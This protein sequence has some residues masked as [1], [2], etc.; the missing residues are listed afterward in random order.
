L[1]SWRLAFNGAEPVRSETLEEFVKTFGECGFSPTALYPCYGMAETTLFTTGDWRQTS[2]LTRLIDS[3]A[4]AKNQIVVTNQPIKDQLLTS[5]VSC[6]RTWL[7][8]EI[9]IVDPELLTRCDPDR[10]GEIWVASQSV[11]QGYWNNP[12]AT[13]QI[14]QARIKNDQNNRQFLRTGDLGFIHDNQ[15]FVTG[16]L[17]DI[18]IIRGRNHYP[19]D[20]EL[21][22]ANSHPALTPNSGAAFMVEIGGEEKLVIAQE[23]ERSQR[24]QLDQEAV[25]FAVYTAVSEFHELQIHALLLLKPGTIPKTSSGKIQRRACHQAFL[26]ETFELLVEP[27]VPESNLSKDRPDHT[28]LQI[29]NQ[30]QHESFKVTDPALVSLVTNAVRQQIAFTLEQPIDRILADRSFHSFGTDS[31]KAV[32]IIENISGQLDLNLL[33]TLLFEYST[34]TDLATYLVQNHQDHLSTKLLNSSINDAKISLLSV[35]QEQKRPSTTNASGDIAVIGMS[36]RFP[37]APNLES[38][39]ELLTNGKTA[40]TEVPT[41]RWDRHWYDINPEAVNKT[42]SRWG[43]FIDGIDLFD[44]FFFQISP[45]E[46][47]LMDPQQ[48]IFLEVAW[49]ALEDAGY[50]PE[51]LDTKSAGVFVGCSKN[52]Y[53]RHIEGQL[54]PGDYSAGIGNQ[55]P[56]IANRVS[57]FLNLHGPSVLVDTLCSS[58]LVSIHMA[59]QSI[60]Q[61]E[62][63]TAIAGG[64]NLQLS[65]EYYVGMS[66]MKVHSPTGQCYAFDDR[67][68]GIVLGEGVG[69]VLLKPLDQAIADGDSIY[70]IIKGS[71]VNN[72][73]RTNGLTAPNPASQADVISLALDNAGVAADTI[74][75]VEAHGTGTSLGDPIEI[76]GLTKAFRVDTDQNHFCAI[77]SVKTNLGHLE[78]AAGIAQFIKVMLSLRHEQLPPSL[79]FERPNPYIPFDTSPFV[80]NQHLQ[81]WKSSTPRRAGISSFGMGGTNAHVVVEEAPTASVNLKMVDRSHHLLLLSAKSEKALDDLVDRYQQLLATYPD[82]SLANLCFTAN[83][84]RVQFNE[85]LGVVASSIG[86]LAVQLTTYRQQQ[87]S[88]NI[89]R[90]SGAK[91]NKAKIACLF[92]G[93][94]SQYLQMG[95]QLYETQP[96]FRQ[97]MIECATL[98]GPYLNQS[99]IGLLYPV[100]GESELIHQ[101]IYAQPALFALEY[102]LFKLWQSWGI[103]PDALLG[104]SLGEYVAAV[105]AGMMSLADGIKLVTI[106]AKLMQD[107]PAE[108]SMLA[109]FA[110][111]VEIQQ[112]LLINGQQLSFAVYNSP[113]NTV[114]AGDQ[115]A[116]SHACEVLTKAGMK[117]KKLNTSNAFHSSLMEPMITEFR[118]AAT[119]VTYHSPKITLIS[120]LTGAPIDKIDGEYWCQH[121]RQSVKFADGLQSLADLNINVFLEIGPKPTLIGIGQQ[122]LATGDRLWLSSLR[123]GTADG[124]QILQCVAQMAISGVEIDWVA[125]DYEFDRHRI[126]LPTYPF[127]RKSYW[128]SEIKD[129]KTST[130]N[131]QVSFSSTTSPSPIID[132]SNQ[133]QQ[134][135]LAQLHKNTASLLK[136]DPADIDVNVPFLEMG[137]DSLVLIE[138]VNHIERTF[139]LKISIRQIFEELTTI[140]L[141]ANYIHEQRPLEET[142]PEPVLAAVGNTVK[143]LTVSNYFPSTNSTNGNGSSNGQG[144]NS[145]PIIPIQPNGNTLSIDAPIGTAPAMLERVI[146]Q[147]MQIQLQLMSKQL[148]TVQGSNS[149]GDQSSPVENSSLQPAQLTHLAPQNQI[150]TVAPSSKSISQS[151]S[152]SFWRFDPSSGKKQLSTQQQ[153]HLDALIA[154]Y[155]QRTQKSKQRARSC[156]SFLADKRAAIGFRFETKEMIYPITGSHSLGSKVWD[157][158]DNEYIDISMGFGVHLFGHSESFIMSALENQLRQGIHIGPLSQLSDKVALLISELT[159]MERVCFSNSGTEAVMTAVRLA[160]STT[161]RNKIVI[162]KDSYHGHSDGTLAVA[163]NEGSV[164]MAPGVTQN[165]VDDVLVL[166]Y[167]DPQSLDIIKAHAHELAAVLVEPVPSRRPDVQPQEFLQQLRQLTTE[168]NIALIFD[169]VITGFRIHPGGAQAWFGIEADIAT[170]G[171]I[172]GGGMPIGVI[173]GKALYLD[174]IDGGD[175]QYED[176]SYP[177]AETTFFAGTFSRNPLAM[178]AAYAVLSQIKLQGLPLYQQLNQRTARLAQTINDFFVREQVPV[179]I[180]NFGSLFRFALAGNASYLY[181]PLEMDLFYYHLIEK[182]VYV[183]EGRTCFLSTSHTDADINY[184]IQAVQDSVRLMKEGGFWSQPSSPKSVDNPTQRQ[185]VTAS[186]TTT[187]QTE[188]QD[189]V[190]LDRVWNQRRSPAIVPDQK[191]VVSISPIHL[192]PANTNKTLDFSLYYFGEYAAEFSQGK[193]DLLF[194]GAKFADQNGFTA[195]WI[196]ERHF[197][198]FGGF[199][200]N[201]SVIGAG[202][203]RETKKIQIRAGSVVLPLHH[204]IRV[205]EEWSVVDNLSQGRVGIA[206]A[207]GWHPNDFALAP[208]SYGNHRELMFQGIET[209][210]KLWR[211]ESIPVRGGAGNE[212]EVQTFPMPMQPQL[213]IWITVVN[214]PETYIR[215]GEIGAGILTNLMNQ[216]VEDLATNIAL[217]REALARNGHD[218][219]SATV[220]VLLH[221]LIGKDLATIRDQ[222]RQPFCNYLRSSLG[223]FQ[224][225]VKSQG[226]QVDLDSLSEDDKNY[227]LSAAYERYVQTSALI[228]TPDSCAPIIDNLRSIGVDEIACFIDFGVDMNGVLESLPYVNELKDRFQ[229]KEQST[230]EKFIAVD[231]A[232]S[233]P[234]TEAQ[235]Q[236][237]FLAQLGDESSIAY[238]ESITLEMQGNLNLGAMVATIQKVVDRH[239]A[240]RTIISEQ[241]DY[242]E[243]LPVLKIDVPIINLSNVDDQAAEFQVTKWLKEKSQ[244]PFDLARGPLFRADILQ[245]AEKKHLLLV[246]AHHIIVDGWSMGLIV[247]EIG[248]IYSA[249]CQGKTVQLAAPLQFREY[250]NWQEQQAT[251]TEI[252]AHES[253]WLSRF[254]GSIPVL[255]LPTDRPRPAVKTFRADQQTVQVSADLSNNLRRIS[256]ENGCTLFM[257]LFSAYSILLKRLTG[258]DD[259]LVGIPTA[260]RSLK[261][262]EGLVG[263][264]THFLPIYCQLEDDLTIVASFK[265]IRSILLDAYDHQD[266]PFAWLINNLAARKNVD[267]PSLITTTFNIDPSMTAPEIVGLQTNL[268]PGQISFADYEIGLNVI[269]SEQGLILNCFYNADLFDGFKITGMLENFQVL[270]TEIVTDIAQQISTLS[271]IAAAEQQKLLV[272]WNH[273]QADYPHEHCIHQLFEAQVNKIPEAIAIVCGDEQLTYQELN[274]RANQLAHHLQTLEIK[275]EVP[276]GVCISRSIEMMVGILGILKAGGAYV[277]LDPTYPAERLAYMLDDA[278]VPV[279]LTESGLRANLPNHKAQVVCLDTDWPTIAQHSSNNCVSAVSPTNLVY[280]IYTSG[281]T[282][283]PKGTMIQHQSLVSYTTTTIR[284]Y[285]MQPTD[286]VLQFCSISFDVAAE[287]IYPCLSSGGALVMRNDEMVGSI[288]NFLATCGAWGITMLSLPT[289][290]WHE[291]V[292]ALGTQDVTMPEAMRLVIIAGE[293]ARP[294]Q[295]AKWQKYCIGRPRLIN[296]YGVTEST[297]IS[298]IGELTH[299]RPTTELS[300][301]KVIDNTQIYLLDK[302]LQ[303]VPIGIPGEMYLGGLLLA[304]GYFNRPDLT[305]E[306]F[307]PHPFSTEPGARIYKTGDLA[308]YRADSSIEC[309]GRIDQQVKIRGFR[310]ELGEVEGAISKHPQVSQVTVIDREDISGNKQLVA[311]IVPQPGQEISSTELRTFLKE[312]LPNHMLPAAFVSLHEFPFTPN[313]KIDRQALP[314]PDFTQLQSEEYVAP[315]NKVEEQLS[316]IW[317]EV[318]GV[319]RVGVHD[320]FFELGGHSLLAT[321]LISRIR[322]VFEVEVPLRKLFEFNTIDTLAAQ[323]QSYQADDSRLGV[324]PLRPVSRTENLPLSFAQQRLWFLDQLEP[325]SSAY[326]MPGAVKLQGQLDLA[327]LERSL[328]EVVRRH[329]SLRTNFI[330]SQDGQPRQV[331][332]KSGDWQMKVIDLQQMLHCEREAQIQQ[333]ATAEATK[334]FALDTDSLLRVTVLLVSETE[335]ILLLT[336]HHIVSDGWSI[337]VL[338]EEIAT[339]YSAFIQGNT[340]PLLELEIQYVDFAVWQRE[341]LQGDTLQQQINYWQQQLAGAPALLELSTDRPRPPVQTFNGANYESTISV[342]ILESLDKLTQQEGA[343]LFMTLLAAFD[344]LLYRYTGQA[345]IVVGSPIANRNHAEIENL[346]GFFA[347]TLILRNDLSD[348]PTFRELLQRVREVALGAYAHQD[349]PFE[350]LVETLQPERNLSYSPLFQVM[351]ILQNTP[352]SDLQMPGVTLSPMAAAGSI[353]TFDITLS[354][355]NT[356]E[357]LTAEWEYNTDLFNASTIKHM[358]QHLE[359]LL[360]GIAENPDSSIAMLP[361]LTTAEQQQLLVDWNDTQADYPHEQCIHQLF[362]AQVDKTPEVIAI[363]CGDEQLTYRELNTR[364]NQLAHHLQI[365]GIKQDEFVGL[366]VERSLEMIVGMLAILKAGGAYVPLDSEYPAERLAYMV[367]DAQISLLLTQERLLSNLPAHNAQVICLDRDW[368]IIEQANSNN[369]LVSTNS[370]DSLAYVIYTSGSTGQPKGVM[371]TQQNLTNFCHAA[372]NAYDITSADRILQFASVSFDVAAEE[373]YPGLIQGA[374]IYLRTPKML[375]SLPAFWQ[376]C[377]AWRLTLLD[378][379]TAYWQQ[380]TTDLASIPASVRLVIIGGERANPAQVRLWQ[381]QV[382][383]YPQL[384]NAYGPT[385]TTVEATC[386]NLSQVQLPPGQEVP[387]GK[388]LANMQV[389][390]LDSQLQLV[391]VGTPGELHIG[392]HGVAKGYL[393]RPDLTAEKF[394]V[395]PFSDEPQARLYKTGDLVRYL[396]DGN[397]E[398]LGRIDQQVKIRGF[399]IELG[400]VEAAISKHSQIAQVTVIDSYACAKGDREDKPGNKVL[401]AYLVTQPG[402]EISST[403]LRTF[404][405]GQLPDYMLPTIAICLEELPVTPNGKID[406]KALPVPDFTQLQAAE[407]VAPRN[408][409]EEQ[410]SSIWQDVLG[411]DQVGVHDNFFELGGHSLLATQL[412]SRIRQTFEIEVPLRKLFEFNTIDALAAQIQSYQADD[413]RLGVIP[414]RPVSRTENLPLSF[415]QQR[416]WFLDQLEPNSSAYNMPGAVK[417]QG[418]LDLAILERTLGEVVRRHE[419]LRTNFIVSQDGQPR[420]V[421]NESGDWQMKVIDLQQMPHREREAQIQQLASAEA[422]KPF[423]LG[424]DSLLRVTVLLVSATEQILLLTMHH[425]VSDGWSIGVLIE[426]IATLY[427]AFIQGNTSPLLELEIQ[428]V[429][430][431][432]WQREWLQGDTLQ[433]QINYWQQQL[434]GAP[435][436][437]ELPTD[438]PRPPVQTFNGADYESTISAHVAESLD[439]LTQQEGVTLFMTLLAAFD[440]LLYRYTGQ[441]DIVVGSPI[442]NRNHAEIENLIGFFANTLILRNDLSDNPTFRELLQ[443][444]R[445]VA[446]GAY[447]H[448]DLPFEMLVETLQPERNLSYSPLFQVMFILQNTPGSDLQMPGVTLSPI[449]AAGSIST[450]DITLSLTNTPEGLIAEWEYNTDLFNA[451]TIERMAQHLEILLTAIAENPDLS[452]STLPMLTT[453][454]QQQ[455]LVDWNDTQADYPQEQCVHQ[456]FEAQVNKTP[457]AI[458]IVCGDEQLT[459]QELNTRANQLAHHLQTLGIKPEVPVGVCI[460]RSIEMMVGIIGVLKAG[461]AYVP[462]DPTYPAERLAYML[463]DAQVPVLLTESGLKANLPNHMAQVVCLDTDWQTIAQQSGN[464]CVSAVSPTN[465][466]YIIYTSGST[467]KPKGTMIQHQSL[468]SYTTTTIREYDMRPTDKVLQFCSISFDVAAEEIYPCLSSGGALV[469]RNDEMVGSIANFL[470]TCRAWGITMLSLPTAYWHEIVAALG[471]QGVTVPEAMRLVIIAGERAR[472][473]Q[474]AKWQEYCISRPRLINTYGVTESTIISTIG[475]LTHERPSTEVSVGKVID[476]TQIYLLDKCLQPVPIGIPGEMYLGGLLLARGYLN[477]PDLTAEKFIPHPFSAELGARIYKTGDLAR[478]RVDGSIECLGRID[479]QVK[480]RGFRIELGEVEAAISKHSQVSQVTV[481]DQEDIPGNKQLVAYIVPQSTQEISSTELRTFLKE[482]LPNHM[483]P[484]AFVSLNEFPFTPNGKIDRRALPAPDFSKELAMQFIAPRNQTEETLV[485]IWME[486]LKIERVGINDNFFDLGGHSLLSLQLMAKI[487]Q[488]FKTNL[489]LSILF[490]NSTI[491]QLA[492]ILHQPIDT[493]IWSPLVA[494]NATGSKP[495]F[496]CIPGGGGNPI[497]FNRLVHY[498]GENQPFYAFQSLGLDGESKPHQQVS[499]I[500]KCYIQ[501]IQSIQPDGPYLLGGHSFGGHVAFEIAQQLKEEGKHVALLVLFDAGDPVINVEEKDFR[502]D[503]GD[504]LYTLGFV[505]ESLYETSLDVSLE[506]LKS[507]SNDGQI[508]YFQECLQTSNIL[509]TGMGEKQLHGLLEVFKIQAQISYHPKGN[510]SIPTIY[511]QASDINDGYSEN[512][513]FTEDVVLRWN[514]FMNK[515]IEICITPGSHFTL[516]NEPHVQILAA[517]LRGYISQSL[518]DE[519]I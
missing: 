303:P 246:S 282:G 79:N 187:V 479:Q 459:Y 309:L 143:E 361:M 2:S 184:V 348:N 114:I 500:A 17:K 448:Q 121:L 55:T 428:Y 179:Q 391:P 489:P 127:Q 480:I 284:E 84:G 78:S 451:S 167:D 285:D 462:L 105:V 145:Q 420:Q 67:A 36:C 363:V 360:T 35:N 463:T 365:L 358:A 471:T 258:Q 376:Q 427:S 168:N 372:I 148:D 318:L 91:P 39:W 107:L 262:S 212:I 242:Q 456:L 321:Q 153:K 325:N 486:V 403:E 484:A 25:E 144:K 189:A 185:A 431:A 74:S 197:H 344:T 245:I 219:A 281:S 213:P 87:S 129:S 382:G 116:I 196:P 85:K 496:F 170:Y 338:I 416:L 439:R 399:R 73:G 253:Y 340:S 467:G 139:G 146:Q 304:R 3:K 263:Y 211:G 408:E 223:L 8:A 229:Q 273:T 513:H 368:P 354:L 103:Q 247:Q 178:A 349:L 296:T 445:E 180:V 386:C 495:P 404:L 70:G 412:M 44:P 1:S 236:L 518:T 288:A 29:D 287:E 151:P 483:L 163:T 343:T 177:Q 278:Q 172:V 470:A 283:K 46:A 327:I 141:L 425:I 118:Q 469:M 320:N 60:R 100:D 48:R 383:T 326:N 188:R 413:S 191:S 130:S 515:P 234:L 160:R 477:R 453:V 292:A 34:P 435:A 487:E 433:Q 437:L 345:D 346:I 276:V 316:S 323:I 221:T 256:R 392:G 394:I 9:V 45:R 134:K 334:P 57:F 411:V 82:L 248:E 158:D 350:M 192:E 96:T 124:E 161:R 165:A 275:P 220:T 373:I 140:A 59:C 499:E 155:T 379:P 328:G 494:M 450:F 66:R 156:R 508:K 268:L 214:N 176:E 62:C 364:A 347:N 400:E 324:I 352:G 30:I 271:I 14:F 131:D 122:C 329:E 414:L 461:G 355:T 446:L 4:L 126:P 222:A 227:I 514:Q 13:E 418:Q 341:W 102:A 18:I 204:P 225:L 104:H 27:S 106:R 491:Q 455:L 510:H 207:S 388:P 331:I 128:I 351:F 457:E 506:I 137:A 68:D 409:F 154:R 505:F 298:T 274:D 12:A 244:V 402:Q 88:P 238:N 380:L 61:G 322:Q 198:S 224:N 488:Q 171:K 472:P 257:T 277:P 370:P 299:E 419:S 406:R 209:V 330:V 286:K 40:I 492:S 159:G 58:S 270:L 353:S 335:Q 374:S 390:I 16:R 381:E 337:G 517:K 384:I 149:S 265:K 72:D 507:L 473:E 231:Q 319:D 378:L 99:I 193:Y 6:G 264:C 65:P 342:H 432:V 421:I 162:F 333:L 24:Q 206:F 482:Q 249:E 41:Q 443:R 95:R 465:L 438:R 166:T 53:Y 377:D 279:L 385:E 295:L 101:T 301:G 32:E 174:G 417:L 113:E 398:Y 135:I 47:E 152:L 314:T 476:N 389:Y 305:A 109:V 42:Y 306:K 426:E 475:E 359:I 186:T 297:I 119:S 199:S 332:N 356:P 239:E 261:N 300:V 21:T 71:A 97:A 434:A 294:E 511:F 444:V 442:A 76:Q 493:S 43:G 291:I 26:N 90:G 228:G 424:T 464:N 133:H 371:V 56:I 366:C 497:Y 147:Q 210:Q 422:A 190:N 194:A 485:N 436:L 173:A 63:T 37:Q 460:S 474:L 311:Y 504:Y 430:F 254:S 393:N 503:D 218:P 33:P 157:I 77:G 232:V 405:K 272:E 241:G 208:E 115:Q 290:Y 108:G 203:A 75:Y 266:Y 38:Y 315:R 481:I 182:G 339:L 93:Q 240:L 440:T 10:V 230:T 243:I 280:I 251:T 94:G 498:L 83:T 336:M 28:P 357:G 69:A 19:Q 169:E 112:V 252:A 15:L 98:M 369:N 111:P 22:V 410:L 468:V 302:C 429:D 125:F 89:Y 407:Y 5:I 502:I 310:I 164:P 367:A 519:G 23:V 136:A 423:A 452:I 217:Y 80:V 110:T 49:E 117:F 509:P 441:A 20:I 293:R 375:N 449:A 250:V 313:G 233:I 181:Q 267:K 226:L 86:N 52:S 92:T 260:G 307:I 195:I 216:T 397:I 31:L 259:I 308:R 501:A 142:A 120:N 51:Q 11:A 7:D 317:Q 50:R 237:W 512:D 516:M 200:P 201:P 466:V 387:I 81:S 54:Q 215:A 415:A 490:Q 478:Y 395:D 269:D 447:A 205:A 396:T 183:W 138:A 150:E 458:A 64:I 312:Q 123:S 202:L 132:M 289:A 175:W 255:E 454:E 401:V 235:K 362:E